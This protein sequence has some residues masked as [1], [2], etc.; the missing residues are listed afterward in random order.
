MKIVLIIIAQYLVQNCKARILQKRVNLDAYKW[1]ADLSRGTWVTIVMT[2]II[3]R[4]IGI[5]QLLSFIKPIFISSFIVVRNYYMIRC[6]PT[7]LID[8]FQ[9]TKST[10]VV[11]TM[12]NIKR[13]YSEKGNVLLLLNN[14]TFYK[15]HITQAGVKWQMYI[16]V[17]YV[18]AVCE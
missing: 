17:V 4:F 12:E 3:L 13:V 16:K 14:Y 15:D 5:R 2:I 10:D 8:T 7:S 11:N 9:Q 18:K 1:I 6:I